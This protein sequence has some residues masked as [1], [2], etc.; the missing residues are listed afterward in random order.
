M[1]LDSTKPLDFIERFASKLNLSHEIRDLC[2]HIVEKADEYNIVSENTPPSIAAGSIYLCVCLCSI[3]IS[4]KDLAT[5]CGIS[6]V[7]LTK[8]YKKLHTHR[9][10]LLPREAILKYKVK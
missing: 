7:T 10:I 3:D 1:N 9:G 2:K 8:C 4:K 6:Q 5:T